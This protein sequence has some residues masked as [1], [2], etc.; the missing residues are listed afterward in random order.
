MACIVHS[1]DTVP[2]CLIIKGIT[3]CGSRF[4]PSDWAH[5]L[6]GAAG[7]LHDGRFHFHPHVRVVIVDGTSAVVVD[8]RLAQ[9]EPHLYDFIRKF[10]SDNDLQL[11]RQ[12]SHPDLP[13]SS[14]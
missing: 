7:R 14:H 9:S 8:E 1:T 3:Q 11:C 12:V 10:G 6:A 13:H 5:R 2:G 4:R